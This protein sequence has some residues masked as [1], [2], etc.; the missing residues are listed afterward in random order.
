MSTLYAQTIPLLERVRQEQAGAGSRMPALF[1]I[2]AKATT[3][4]G[5]GH[6]KERRM[7]PDRRGVRFPGFPANKAVAS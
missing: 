2:D 5:H 3:R 1:P 7:D 6:W 4:A